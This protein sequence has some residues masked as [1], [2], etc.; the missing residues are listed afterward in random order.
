[1]VNALSSLKVYSLTYAPHYLHPNNTLFLNGNENDEDE[2]LFTAS[3]GVQ[4]TYPVKLDLLTDINVIVDENIVT[5]LVQQKTNYINDVT[6]M[7]ANYKRSSICF[8]E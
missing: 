2:D 1:M 5:K 3:M 4:S 7:T 8:V 6:R